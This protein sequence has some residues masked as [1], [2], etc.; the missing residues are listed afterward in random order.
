MVSEEKTFWMH[1]ALC[2]VPAFLCALIS[3]AWVRTDTP[4]ALKWSVF[5]DLAK[6][7]HCGSS[8]IE[9]NSNLELRT[10]LIKYKVSSTFVRKNP[11]IW[12]EIN[13]SIFRRNSMMQQKKKPLTRD[14]IPGV[15]PRHL[16]LNMDKPVQPLC[17]SFP[18]SKRQERIMPQQPLLKT[19][20]REQLTNT[21][22]KL[23]NC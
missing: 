5:K 12:L 13:M 10:G 19:D 2:C 18:I 15:Y 6:N 8:W 14:R 22:H 16:L 9:F 20:L 4:E 23:F 3:W 21:L 1:K 17:L 11:V 7:V